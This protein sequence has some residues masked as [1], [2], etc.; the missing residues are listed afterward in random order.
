[1]QPASG[2]N[3]DNSPTSADIDAFDDLL[4]SGYFDARSYTSQMRN[5]CSRWLEARVREFAIWIREYRASGPE[6]GEPLLEMRENLV[7]LHGQL[8][9]L[10]EGDDSYLSVGQIEFSELAQEAFEEFT[11]SWDNLKLSIMPLYHLFANAYDTAIKDGRPIDPQ[12]M[13][14]NPGA[15]QKE[16]MK[17]LAVMHKALGKLAKELQRSLSE[18]GPAETGR[19]RDAGTR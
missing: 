3:Q 1:M 18:A 7:S 8:D 2:R 9:M 4:R 19:S 16:L 17:T 11:G 14:M 12:V 5:S 13:A 15:M 6:L 10:C